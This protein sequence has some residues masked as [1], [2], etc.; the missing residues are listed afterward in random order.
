MLALEFYTYFIIIISVLL[1]TYIKI[2]YNIII[3][4]RSK[5]EEQNNI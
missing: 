1:K 2:E 4:H 3:L 5:N